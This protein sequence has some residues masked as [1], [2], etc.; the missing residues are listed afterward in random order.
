MDP[1]A[2]AVLRG[3][4]MREPSAM[5]RQVLWEHGALPS[6][7]RSPLDGKREGA[8]RSSGFPRIKCL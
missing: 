6:S 4:G 8:P 3:P 2:G 5:L 7:A 1:S